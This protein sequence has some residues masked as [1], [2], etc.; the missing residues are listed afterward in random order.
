MGT[1]FFF[2]CAE[3]KFIGFSGSKTSIIHVLAHIKSLKL[4][5]L[6]ALE[7]RVYFTYIMGGCQR[8]ND[9][10]FGMRVR[11]RTKKKK[12]HEVSPEE[13]GDRVDTNCSCE[14]VN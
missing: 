3:C 7:H 4:A 6:C 1:K 2:L 10:A 11:H 8:V 12:V 13:C 14:F 9:C 5:E